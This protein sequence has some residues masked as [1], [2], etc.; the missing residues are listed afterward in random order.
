M[1][2]Q[3]AAVAHLRLAKPLTTAYVLGWLSSTTPRL[4]RILLL[5]ARR[6]LTVRAAWLHTVDTLRGACAIHRFPAFCAVLVGGSTLLQIPIKALLITALPRLRSSPKSFDHWIAGLLARFSAALISASVSFQ[7]LNS[8][9]TKYAPS[10]APGATSS[11][12]KTSLGP[13]DEP[14][15][16]HAAEPKNVL[17]LTRP[18][19]AGRTLD[20]TLFAVVRALD[21]AVCTTTSSL[22]PSSRL[23]Q[24]ASKLPTPLFC[25]S[26]ATIMWSWFYSPSRLPQNYNAWISAA[27]G[28]DHRLMLALRHARYGTFQY[29]KHTGMAPLLGSMARDYG[30]PEEAGDPAKTVPVPCELVHMGCGKSCEKHALWRFWR[31][32]AFAA[33]MYFPLQLFVLARHLRKTG[34]PGDR[35]AGL[36]QHT[37]T[38]AFQEATWRSSFLGA[39]VAFFYYGVCLSRTR[40]GPSIFS[41]RTV[42]PQMWDSGLCV[43]SGCLLCGLSILVEESRRRLEMVLFV[44]PRAAATWLPRRYL[45]EHRWKEHLAFALSAAVVMTAA[46]EDHRRVRGVLGRVLHRVLKA[47]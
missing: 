21:V 47:D 26:A 4:A 34:R 20:L 5:F 36:T 17:P 18:D 7:L 38:A 46:Q 2:R 11:F 14:P 31:G 30:M 6:K 24:A 15:E 43:L 1:A 28:L 29:G 10:T 22:Q 19:L 23:H 12:T 16:Q 27:A 33:K 25:L 41:S 37:L 32:W 45:P 8:A 35:F 39:F 44:L 9:P 13:F 42:T 3:P 40:L